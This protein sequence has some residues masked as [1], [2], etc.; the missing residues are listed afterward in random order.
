M[1]D[2]KNSVEWCID[3]NVPMAECPLHG[4]P[5]MMIVSEPEY[6]ITPEGLKQLQEHAEALSE[7]LEN[8]SGALIKMSIQL[9]EMKKILNDRPIIQLVK[10]PILKEKP[11]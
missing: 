4:P 2:I 6:G 9:V 1:S 3:H 10:N 11:E 7:Q 5:I 8:M